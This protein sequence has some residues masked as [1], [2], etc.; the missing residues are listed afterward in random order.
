MG[1]VC[2]DSSTEDR[3]PP[4]RV[5]FAGA[6]SLAAIYG[7]YVPGRRKEMDAAG[8]HISHGEVPTTE[9][10]EARKLLE[11]EGISG[12]WASKVERRFRVNPPPSSHLP[13][14][15]S[16]LNNPNSSAVP[17]RVPIC[18]RSLS[19]GVGQG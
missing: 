4:K 14:R 12:L 2:K 3:Q 15:N 9:D 13:D 11:L 8:G 19:A 1:V 18:F 10:A 17:D 16:V 6:F 7:E 5:E